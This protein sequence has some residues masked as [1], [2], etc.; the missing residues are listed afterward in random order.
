M[1]LGDLETQDHE[2]LLELAA[3]HEAAYAV[4]E[5]ADA[6]ESL[7]KAENR[8]STHGGTGGAGLTT[9]SRHGTPRTRRRPDAAARGRDGDQQLIDAVALLNERRS[10]RSGPLGGFPCARP[11]VR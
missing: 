8:R 10:G 2:R 6:A 11:V 9:G 3:R 5:S 1:L 4:P 7:A